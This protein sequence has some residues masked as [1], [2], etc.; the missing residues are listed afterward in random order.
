MP[1][2]T[3][4]PEFRA[5]PAEIARITRT[6][7]S[8]LAEDHVILTK[9]EL[10]ELVNEAVMETVVEMWDISLATYHNASVELAGVISAERHKGFELGGKT[11]ERMREVVLGQYSATF[12]ANH[13]E[14]SE[15]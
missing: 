13:P 3:S 7:L 12:S 8:A 6:A 11:L 4:E 14:N 10:S 2:L 5:T 9:T 1:P 15:K